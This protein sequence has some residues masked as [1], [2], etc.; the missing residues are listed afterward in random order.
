L[1]LEKGANGIYDFQLPKCFVF[2]LHFYPPNEGIRKKMD[3]TPIG[4]AKRHLSPSKSK[5]VPL[6]ALCLR[7]LLESTE[8]N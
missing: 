3:T 5:G 8:G 2:A 1:R 7:Q 4:R 6:G